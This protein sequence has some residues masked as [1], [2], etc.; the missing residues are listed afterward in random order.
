M[1]FDQLLSQQAQ[2]APTE[3]RELWASLS[4]TQGYGYLRD[5]QAQVLTAWD[6]RRGERDLVV[7]VNTGGG[8]TIDGLV[9]LQSYLNAGVR[10]ALYVCPSRYL[11]EQVREEATHLGIETIDDP[12]HHRYLSGDA[13]AVVTADKLFNGRSVFAATRPTRA[14]APIGAVVIDDAHAAIATSRS[15]L[16]ITLPSAH[17][18]FDPLLRLF[19]DELEE[20]SPS[21]L[22]QIRAHTHSAL[23]RV[24]F[25]AW[26]EKCERARAI[27]H[28]HES[29]GPLR[30][31]L[32]AVQDVLPLCRAVFTGRELTITPP[33]PPVRNITGFV[34]AA[35]RVYLTATLADDSVLVTD[36]GADPDSVRRPITP[37]TAGDIGE[38]MILAPQEINPSII[39]DHTRA[40]IAEL[41][42][43]YN[44]VV[45]VPSYRAAAEWDEWTPRV[46]N[47]DNLAATVEELRARHVGLVVLVNKYDGVD[48]PENACRILVVDGLPEVQTG[49]E[50]LEAQIARR[51]GADDRQVQRIEQGM[52][53]GVRSNEDHCVVFLL[54]SRLSQLVADPR[55]RARFSAATQ[56]QLELSRDV[57]GRMG[58]SELSA[59]IAV[60]RQALTRDPGWV[61]L[62]KT[63]LRS[64]PA[65]TGHVS[66]TAVARRRAFEAATD[67]D[68]R[69]AAEL[70][71]AAVSTLPTDREQGWLLEQKA[72]YLDLVDPVESQ[73]VLSAAR[74]KNTMVLRPLSGF[75]YRRLSGSEDQAQ[76]AADFLDGRYRTGGEL[77]LGFQAIADDL[78]FDPDCT[79]EAEE[80]LRQLAL[81]IGFN[82]Q[83]P[84]D[85]WGAGPDVLWALGGLRFWV[86]EAKTGATTDL[87]HKRDAN[88]LSGSVLWLTDKYGADAVGTP[89]MVHP[90]R[91]LAD[92]ATAAPDA[93]ALTENG[94]KDLRDAFIALG[95]GL[96]G[97]RWDD[98]QAVNQLLVGHRLRAVDLAQYLK[99]IRPG[100]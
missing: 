47:A 4:K 15:Q 51:A 25:W 68:T 96:A 10:P 69:A 60:A 22:L 63:K 73:Q 37:L 33:V 45:L 62:A 2:A 58:G 66:D 46:I 29:S 20:H 91:S 90:A 88:Q 70:I 95:A 81:H 23:A 75:D 77:R 79:D 9:I 43:T 98:K 65:P 76:Q 92:D 27:L 16:S 78:A 36:F 86:I 54:G 38:R 34:E 48:L 24:P 41:S 3:P 40:E 1:D 87:I 100:R 56:A 19:Q 21:S 89:V 8:K 74:R 32:P 85:E 6:A 28:Q 82:A 39:V 11:V 50:R 84:E 64:V 67:G 94:L 55:T 44:T 49:D 93:R 53:R 83:R 97:A 99:V 71:S 80:A 5:V 61:Q 17:P 31:A 30:Y 26:R 52:G 14:P 35:H 7:K 18:A 57:A 42:R 59:I 72:A 13:I 12:D